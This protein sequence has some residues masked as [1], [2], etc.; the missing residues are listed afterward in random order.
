MLLS[1][2][3][4]KKEEQAPIH[5]LAKEIKWFRRNSTRFPKYCPLTDIFR[6]YTRF[7][8]NTMSKRVYAELGERV[9]VID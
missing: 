6:L 7:K 2:N 3:V 5:L 4:E 8:K 1:I 9:K